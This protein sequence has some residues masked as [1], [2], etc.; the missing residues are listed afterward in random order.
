MELTNTQEKL[1]DILIVDDTPAN[2]RVLSQLLADKGY[3]V[4]KAING[5]V[6][7]RAA[8]I[9][10]PDLIL[11]DIM[12]PHMNGYEVCQS[13]KSDV[14]TQDIPI[15]FL[16]A[17]SEGS[18]KVKAFEVGG[19]DYVTKPFQVE[20]VLARVQHQL[21][22]QLQKKEL[23]AKTAKLQQEILERQQAESQLRVLYHAITASQ[24]G[25]LITDATQPHHP[26]VYVNPGFEKLTG[27]AATEVLDQ[28]A[29]FLRDDPL[30]KIQITVLKKAIQEEQECTVILQS[31]RKNGMNWWNQ[32]SISP[33]K[34]YAGKLTHYIGIITDI[35]QV[36]QMEEALIISE[37][38][39]SK[40]FQA[41]PDPIIISTLSNGKFIEVNDSFCQF[42]GYKKEEIINHTAGDLKI[43]VNQEDQEKITLILQNQGYIRNEEFDVCSKSGEVKTVLL[44]AETIQI[45]SESCL[46]TVAKDITERK[47]AKA[48]LEKANELLHHLASSDSLTQVANRRRFDEYLNQIWTRLAHDQY[49][50]SLIMCDVDYFKFY[51]DTYGHQKGDECLQQVAQAIN[52]MIRRPKDLVARYGGEE[53]AVILP[54]T[55]AEGAILVAERIRQFVQDLKLLH[56][57]SSVSPWVTVSLGV[58]T[59]IPSDQMSPGQ[60][61]AMADQALYQAKNQGR[62]RTIFI[63]VNNPVF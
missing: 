21:T 22:I 10:P 47:Q 43:W 1:R 38:K 58:S 61:V 52:A 59:V 27:Y 46:I 56:E 60:L 53:F 15:I 55:K 28:E 31:Q 44:S 13:L 57:S 29:F 36:K 26:I 17:L 20:E 51:N 14:R 45:H 24:N 33:V 35:T 8:Q 49:P 32:L 3:Q 2:L 40:A 42:T 9:A 7:L 18:D 6:A 37:E 25:I 19:V 30:N 16:S 48:A 12:M 23:E 41:S 50:L 39:F 63:P 54:T 11:L 62:D 4:R 34:D 5:E